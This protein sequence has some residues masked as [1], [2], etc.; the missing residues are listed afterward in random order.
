MK[1]IMEVLVL[2]FSGFALYFINT[3]KWFSV[4]ERANL[5]VSQYWFQQA[6]FRNEIYLYMDKMRGEGLL[7]QLKTNLKDMKTDEHFNTSEYLN[8]YSNYIYQIQQLSR[9]MQEV[10]YN[11]NFIINDIIFILNNLNINDLTTTEVELVKNIRKSFNSLIAINTKITEQNKNIDSL[12]LT[13]N[14]QRESSSRSIKEVSNENNQTKKILTSIEAELPLVLSIGK[15]E[16]DQAYGVKDPDYLLK[17]LQ[18]YGQEMTILTQM[19]EKLYSIYSQQIT[20]Q[21]TSNM[22]ANYVVYF[23]SILISIWLLIIKNKNHESV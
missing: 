2:L 15:I 10:G 13:I 11:G 22:I 1:F 16:F 6:Y 4:S 14:N 8:T 9:M 12:L 20:K 21:K 23:A 3:S 17:P 18:E 5:N 19:Y 7:Y